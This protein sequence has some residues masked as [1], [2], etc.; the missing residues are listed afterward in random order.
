MQATANPNLSAFGSIEG[1]ALVNQDKDLDRRSADRLLARLG[2]L[3]DAPPLFGSAT[4][5]PRAG[6]LL[7]LPVLVASG[8]FE[9][10][11]KNLRQ[12]WPSLL[13]VAHQLADPS[14]HGTMADQTA[15]G[16][17]G[18]FA[19]ELGARAGI[20]PGAGSQNVATQIGTL[21]RRQK[22]RALWPSSGPATD[23]LARR[24]SGLP[25]R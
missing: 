17:Q 7:A 25:L 1:S 24:G 21:G 12:P 15:R 4:A 19:P 18:V 5:V 10:R 8:A 11:A 13:W 23:R 14:A 16:P 3:E 20:G 9:L 22:G 6:A 2:L